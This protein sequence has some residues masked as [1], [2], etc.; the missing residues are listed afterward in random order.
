MYTLHKTEGIIMRA[1]DTGEADKIF[2]VFSRDFGKITLHARG[3]R[4][5]RSKLKGHLN[6]LSRVRLAF[7]AGQDILRLTDAEEG[8]NYFHIMSPAALSAMGRALR[9]VD[10]LVRGTERDEPLWRLLSEYLEK[11]K[12]T[13]LPPP[14]LETLF[15][16]RLLG[17]LGYVST[18][19][20]HFEELLGGNNWA[21]TQYSSFQDKL[22]DLCRIG[23]AASH[24]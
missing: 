13:A 1:Q 2:T 24:L 16:A 18:D 8:E 21:E 23:L 3:V 7:I 10:R 9:L 14:I 4:L 22:E 17:V 20:E 19:D 12:K 11:L 6:I 5:A 15:N